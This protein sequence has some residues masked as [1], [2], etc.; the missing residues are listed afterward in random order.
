MNAETKQD[1]LKEASKKKH[2]D[3]ILF[4]GKEIQIGYIHYRVRKITNKDIIL[5]PLTA[6]QVK[7]K[8]SKGE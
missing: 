3:S 8:L 5:R 1:F 4:V 6:E 2:S 7:R